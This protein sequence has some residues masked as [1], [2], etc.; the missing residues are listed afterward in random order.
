MRRI[1]FAAAAFVLTGCSP[2][3]TEVA[4]ANTS[5]EMQACM[6]A[7]RAEVKRT[8]SSPGAATPAEV[9]EAS[10]DSCRCVR[11][12]LTPTDFTWMKPMFEIAAMDASQEA[13]RY[14]ME[15]HLNE[16]AGT[17]SRETLDARLATIG[18]LLTTECP[19]PR[20]QET[21]TEAPAE[22]PYDMAP[23]DPTPEAPAQTP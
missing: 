8:L 23:T 11:R 16:L 14:R 19:N 12:I 6:S 13:K 7:A 18:D 1:L 9:E 5:P 3:T 21:V 20:V 15:S 10:L 22:A 17:G 4:E 2:A